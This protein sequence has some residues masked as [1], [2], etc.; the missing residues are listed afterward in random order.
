MISE[1]IDIAIRCAGS[2]GTLAKQCGV[3][4]ATVWKWRHG[5][6]VK[7]EH[8]LKIVAA[9]SGQVAAYQIRPDLPELFPKPEKEQ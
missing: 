3:S 5:K 1:P 7:A 4:Q 2:Q 6:K 8:V 9:A